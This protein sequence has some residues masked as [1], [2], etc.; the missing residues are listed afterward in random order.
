MNPRLLAQ[1]VAGG[2]VV[3][4]LALVVKPTLVTGAWVG[5]DEG[6]RPGARVLGTGLGGRDVVVGAGTL[7]A[8]SAGGDG[9][10]PWLV[11]SVVADAIDLAGTLRA[12]SELPTSAVAGA[13]AVAGGAMA[14][15]IWLLSQDVA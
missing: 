4:G 2:R 6:S 14:A 11:G 9:A 3:V 10:R 1:L 13:A 8:L 15:G 7:A 5:E 12:A